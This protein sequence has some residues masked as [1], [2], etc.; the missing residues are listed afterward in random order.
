MKDLRGGTA[1]VTG[2]S[3]GIG[4]FIARGLA[5]EGM[6]VVVSGRRVDALGSVVEELRGMGVRAEAVP[7][8]LFDLKQVESLIDR[9]EA[10]LGK[11][12]LQSAEIARG[13]RE[14]RSDPSHARARPA[15]TAACRASDATIW[16]HRDIPARCRRPGTRRLSKR[17]DPLLLVAQRTSPCELADRM[18]SLTLLTAL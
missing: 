5:R 2:A 18:R 10:V 1:L 6:D 7:A 12:S 17:A 4:T 14:R 3:G 16:S 8:D 9:S 13:G 11:S 15:R